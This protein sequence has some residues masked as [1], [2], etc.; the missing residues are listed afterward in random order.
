M[1]RITATILVTIIIT[2][3]IIIRIGITGITGTITTAIGI[4]GKD[5]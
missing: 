4:V 2:R 3:T 1:N 5:G